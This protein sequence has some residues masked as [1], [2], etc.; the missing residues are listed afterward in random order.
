MIKLLGLALYVV[1]FVGIYN[2]GAWILGT[3]LSPIPLAIIIAG[4]LIAFVVNHNKKEEI[5]H[6]D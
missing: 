2:V 4:G 6:D 3:L 1:I 5:K